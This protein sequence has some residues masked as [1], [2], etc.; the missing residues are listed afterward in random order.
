MDSPALSA[1]QGIQSLI[2]NF[3]FLIEKPEVLL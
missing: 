2:P 1:S 3:S